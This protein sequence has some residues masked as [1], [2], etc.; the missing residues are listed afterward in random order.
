MD[1]TIEDETRQGTT[2]RTRQREKM[3][4]D[5]SM[6]ETTEDTVGAL[7]PTNLRSA[8]QSIGEILVGHLVIVHL[9]VL[10]FS[11]NGG[12]KGKGGQE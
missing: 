7:A 2:M 10:R 8:C 1:S 12:V 9:D 4:Q 5:K 11:D 6:G 3:R